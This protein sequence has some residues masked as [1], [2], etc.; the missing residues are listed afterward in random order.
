VKRANLRVTVF[1]DKTSGTSL[2]HKFDAPSYEAVK[3]CVM[4][5][6]AAGVWVELVNGTRVYVAPN[7][8][9]SVEIAYI[10]KLPI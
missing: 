6:T 10:E 3:D 2:E 5:I 8:I 4:Q 7:G 9:E 1:I